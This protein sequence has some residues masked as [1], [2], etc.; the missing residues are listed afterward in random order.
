MESYKIAI[1]IPAYNEE[2]TLQKVISKVSG[3]G[4]IIVVD[5]G[6]T[7]KTLQ[8]AK[9]SKAIVLENKKNLGYDLSLN[10]GL[11]YIFEKKY[12]Y[13]ITFDADNQHKSSELEKFINYI[14][15]DQFG[16]IIGIRSRQNRFSEKIFNYIFKYIYNVSDILCGLK[17]YNVEILRA[18]QA[19]DF[20]SSLG[21]R[22]ILLIALNKINIKEINITVNEREDISRIGGS[23][24][25]N[26]IILKTLLKVLK[27]IVFWKIY[28]K[29]NK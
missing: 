23:I 21:T 8:I 15:T 5:D 24:K 6:S 9:Q 22:L 18:I 16:A 27:E 20:K 25:S 11:K 3:Y 4:D 2:N 14:S 13:F 19:F 10:I 12:K 28:A 29:K 7:D 17:A 26:L 1:L